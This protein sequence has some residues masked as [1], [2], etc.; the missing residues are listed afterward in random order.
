MKR[1]ISFIIFLAL[2]VSCSL[3]CA[4]EPQTRASD[5]IVDRY[6]YAYAYAGGDVKFTADMTTHGSVDKLGF[7]SIKLQEKQGSDWVTVKSASNKYAYNSAF[8]SYSI[9]FSGTSGN[10]YR[11]VVEYYAKD[12]SVSDTKTKTSSV[13]IAK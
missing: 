8:H 1:I 11:V 2:V 12:G 10:E 5:L 4:S 3:A 7:P 13:L 6:I 9:S